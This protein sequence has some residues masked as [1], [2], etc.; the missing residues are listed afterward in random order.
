MIHGRWASIE[1]WFLGSTGSGSEAGKVFDT[2]N[3][4]IRRITRYATRISEQNNSGADRREEYVKIAQLFWN[5][6]TLEEAH[7]LSSVVFGIEKPLHMKGD[8]KRE[9]ESINSGVYEE[10]PAMFTVV[11]R[12][13]TYREKSQRKG[14]VDRTKEKEKMKQE[15]LKNLKQQQELLDSYV[16]GNRLEFA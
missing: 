12:V 2:T 15:N 10:K 6:E 14:I 7:R 1:N 16:K 5:C 3:E 4:I 9:T 13:R 11:P 8:I